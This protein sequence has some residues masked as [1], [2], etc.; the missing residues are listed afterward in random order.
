VGAVASWS[1]RRTTA[2]RLYLTAQFAY[3][4]DAAKATVS[5]TPESAI[6]Q[7][8]QPAAPAPTPAPSPS[9]VPQPPAATPAPPPATMPTPPPAP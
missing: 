5:P 4:K 3:D 9:P 2:E 7:A 6:P 1:F 8:P